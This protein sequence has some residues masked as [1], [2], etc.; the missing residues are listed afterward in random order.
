MG[1]LVY[2]TTLKLDEYPQ[3][4][5]KYRLK[6]KVE[7]G[8]GP[9]GNAAYLLSLWGEEVYIAG[10]IGNDY[11]G[12]KVKEEFK[13][14]G[15]NTKYLKA[16]DNINTDSSYIIANTS[17]GSRTILTIKNRENCPLNVDITENFDVLVLDGEEAHISKEVL[18]RNPNAISIL[19]AGNLRQGTKE[20]A[21]LVNYLICSHDYAEDIT[22]MKMNYNDINS[23]IKIY[24]KMKEIYKNNVIITL[25]EAG[26][27]TKI[28]DEYKIIPSI[29]IDNPIDSTGAGD[30]FHGAFAYFIT[31]NYKIEKVLRLSNIAGALSIRKLGSKNSMPRLQD[32]IKED[33][34]II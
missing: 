17:K 27:F 3:E 8:G 33:E 15:T 23:I 4:N 6:S 7:C 1:H 30:I 12:N 11:Q 18:R 5:E 13:K 34:D 32:V 2:D 10:V 31:K 25:E 14:V 22:N 20:L 16:S 24:D 19:D 28:N 26:C 29:K 9:A 21:Q